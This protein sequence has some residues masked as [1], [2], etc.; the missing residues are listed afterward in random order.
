MT[1]AERMKS[2]I[3]KRQARERFWQRPREVARYSVLMDQ[4]I[5]RYKRGDKPAVGQRSLFGEWTEE[6]E[7]KHPRVPKGSADPQ[8]HGGEFAKKED[9]ATTVAPEPPTPQQT[10]SGVP[11][12]P[13]V[14]LSP[15]V[16]EEPEH[17]PEAAAAAKRP[18]SAEL[19]AAE[20]TGELLRGGE[21]EL[22]RVGGRDDGRT[23]TRRE[24]KIV[25][26]R[27]EL[28]APADPGLVSE[29][30]REHLSEHQVQGTAKALSAMRAHGGFIL[31]DG[32]G[33]GKSRQ[34]LAVAKTFADEGKKV[35]VVAPSEVIKPD[36]K[37][38]TIQGS[39]ADDGRAMGI[40]TYL[41][42]GNMP[43]VPGGIHVTSYNSLAKFKDQVDRNTVLLFDEAHAAKNFPASARGKQ[44][45]DSAKAAHSVM[46]ASATP[47]DKPL[48]LPYLQRSGVFGGGKWDDTYRALGMISEQVSNGRGGTVTKWKINPRVGKA[49]VRRRLDGLF[50]KMTEEGLMIKREISMD[51]VEVGIHQIPLPPEAHQTLA[52]IED[53]YGGD[54]AV[55]LK[56]AQML[57]QQRRQQEPYKIPATI[58]DAKQALAEGR[59]VVIFAA[60]VNESEVNPGEQE[61]AVASSQG[62]LPLLKAALEAEGIH[63]I[64]EIHGGVGKRKQLADMAAFQSG[65][66]RICIATIE[67]GGTGVN[68]DDRTGDRPRT[69][70]IMSAP[71][72]AVGAVQAAGRVHR[73][74]TKSNSRIKFLFGD[75]EVDEW[76]KALIGTKMSTLGA[77][78][79]GEFARLD[80]T[81]LEGSEEEAAENIGEKSKAEE[82][83]PYEWPRSLIGAAARQKAGL[84]PPAERKEPGSAPSVDESKP[85]E[86][87]SGQTVQVSG[88]T[89]DH[90]EAIKKAA[91]AVGGRALFANGGW[92]IPAEAQERLKHLRGLRFNGGREETP[93]PKEEGE[94]NIQSEPQIPV[95][96]ERKA[97]IHQAVRSLHG[98]NDDMASERNDVG[99]NK[100]DSAFGKQLAEASELTDNQARA[101]HKMLLKYK[102]QLGEHVINAIGTEDKL[103]TQP[104]QAPAAPPIP[105]VEA[106]PDD[107][108]RQAAELPKSTARKA[109][110][111]TFSKLRSG[112]WGVRL[113]GDA[114]PGDRITVKKK[115]GSTTSAKLVRRVWNDKGVSLW[116]IGRYLM[117]PDGR[118]MRYAETNDLAERV[119]YAM[120]T[121]Q[122][123]ASIQ[124][125]IAK[126]FS[127]G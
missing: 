11:E 4:L 112:D 48:H 95:S 32:T 26:G 62:T 47:I 30:L 104:I 36:W 27:A 107:E 124:A 23:D 82:E 123:P 60:R 7:K 13:P 110:T 42:Q 115:D 84:R 8:H 18:V 12:P 51:G 2:A 6:D 57:M 80:P 116:E 120:R 113:E 66:K 40:G 92:T 46:F 64:A 99:Y 88:N 49:E 86:S 54:E 3:A 50:R 61:E 106:Q 19:P 69:M 59:S 79:S 52:D 118:T 119:R 105:I 109:S 65:E 1:L 76:N 44:V 63:D 78:V 103:A 39:Y 55:G 93:T 71:F 33:V 67:S 38:G 127:G 111:G 73:L 21:S 102:K 17:G 16:P 37:K 35:L 126:A 20:P 122:P 31:A 34:I 75:S 22:G 114:E 97:A 98:A 87:A 15:I 90:K 96:A 101:A 9:A 77:S 100:F 43:L 83:A 94:H 89:F 14:E 58:E 72:S 91:A 121:W 74:T 28:T 108:S 81:L 68:L 41:N 29:S 24:G 53:A 25:I 70:L 5:A 56:K 45:Y 117:E 125:D 10:A 85:K